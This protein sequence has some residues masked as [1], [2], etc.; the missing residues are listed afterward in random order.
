MKKHVEF[1]RSYLNVE[2]GFTYSPKISRQLGHWSH[3]IQDQDTFNK[4]NLIIDVFE[5]EVISSCPGLGTCIVFPLTRPLIHSLIRPIRRRTSI[6][7]HICVSLSKTFYQR[8]RRNVASPFHNEPD[9]AVK[10][11]LFIYSTLEIL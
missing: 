9:N 5:R 11:S 1:I 10:L 3:S 4:S 2:D 8:R 7:S 6:E